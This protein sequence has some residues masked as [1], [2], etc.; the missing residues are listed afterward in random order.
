MTAPHFPLA[1][2]V[3][4]VRSLGVSTEAD[5]TTP[6][7]APVLGTL[8]EEP[9]A[10]ARLVVWRG[11]VRVMT[12]TPIQLVE[13]GAGRTWEITTMRTTYRVRAR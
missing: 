5:L 11:G 4:Y 6:T 9:R 13:P 10:G 8:L 3:S 1:V 12:T 2:R 7:M